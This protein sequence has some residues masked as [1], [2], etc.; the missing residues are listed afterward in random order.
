MKVFIKYTTVA[1]KFLTG[2]CSKKFELLSNTARLSVI[3]F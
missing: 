1:F 3:F 2:A